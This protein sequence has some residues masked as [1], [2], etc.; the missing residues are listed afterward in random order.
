MAAYP[1]N[2]MALNSGHS[3]A[4]LEEAKVVMDIKKRKFNLTTY[5]NEH[6]VST[7]FDF[8]KMVNTYAASPVT[9]G[10]NNKL[11]KL[12]NDARNKFYQ[13]IYETSKILGHESGLPVS[14]FYS[15]VVYDFF[16]IVST[17]L[18]YS[19]TCLRVC[20]LAVMPPCRW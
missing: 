5:N 14:V 7:V 18:L 9:D 16:H 4:I 11:R 6:D 10:T 20:T 1:F 19:Y 3:K 2:K 13:L 12:N 15:L 8:E 17:G